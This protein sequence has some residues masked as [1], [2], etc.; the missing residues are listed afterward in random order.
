MK[1]LSLMLP[2]D[3]KNV[4]SRKTVIA[5]ILKKKISNQIF[6]TL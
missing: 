2:A 4:D 1:I 3:L 6:Y 5:T